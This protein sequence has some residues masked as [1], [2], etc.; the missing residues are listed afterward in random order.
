[1]I[2]ASQRNGFIKRKSFV[3]NAF[4]TVVKKGRK[5]FGWLIDVVNSS[6]LSQKK[7]GGANV[8]KKQKEIR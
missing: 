3:F 7:R 2:C 1:M 5:L 8:I 6:D 4:V